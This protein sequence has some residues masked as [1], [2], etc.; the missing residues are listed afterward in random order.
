MKKI[1]IIFFFISSIFDKNMNLTNVKINTKALKDY[2]IYYKDVTV[3][4]YQATNRQTDNTPN[5]TASGF[6]INSINPKNH[7]I[8]A[9]SRDL[10]KEIKFG[11]K[12]RIVGTDIYDG[13]YTVRDIM[14]QRWTNRIDILINLNDRPFLY[15]N[16]KLYRID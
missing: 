16:I 13:V 10:K 1:I 9:I 5:I 6:R 2:G 14:H 12:V 11:Q 8:I 15:K 4:C 7:R 3:T